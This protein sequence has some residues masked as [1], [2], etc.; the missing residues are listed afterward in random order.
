[1]RGYRAGVV[2]WLALSGNAWMV[3]TF[4]SPQSAWPGVA[5]N[6]LALVAVAFFELLEHEAA[7]IRVQ[8]KAEAGSANEGLRQDVER[9][10]TQT[11]ALS[12]KAALNAL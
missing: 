11:E 4:S 2:V 9:L 7:A 10:K 3:D 1:M 8:A 5:L 6:G 12:R